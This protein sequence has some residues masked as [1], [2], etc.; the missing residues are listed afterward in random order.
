[1][2]ALAAMVPC[3]LNRRLAVVVA[4]RAT[5]LSVVKDDVPSAT[6]RKG[7][8]E[9]GAGRVSTCKLTEPPVMAPKDMPFSGLTLFITS[10]MRVDTQ[11]VR[12]GK[13]L[14][15]VKSTNCWLRSLASSTRFMAT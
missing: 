7:T 8:L 6:T 9:S 1:M 2:V 15:T 12:S 13:V 4:V 3:K 10:V 5:K 14:V 11:R